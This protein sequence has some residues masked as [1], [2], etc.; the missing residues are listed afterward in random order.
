VLPRREGC[1]RRPHVRARTP[2]SE[3]SSPCGPVERR[4]DEVDRE[5]RLEK[6]SRSSFIVRVTNDGCAEWAGA[7]TWNPGSA[8][9]RINASTAST[10]PAEAARRSRRDAMASR[11]EVSARRPSPEKVQ[12]GSPSSR[13][14]LCRLAR[15]FFWVRD[16]PTVA[17]VSHLISHACVASEP[18]APLVRSFPTHCEPNWFRQTSAPSPTQSRTRAPGRR[19]RPPPSAFGRTGTDRTKES[20]DPRP[21]PRTGVHRR[22]HTGARIGQIRA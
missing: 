21:G 1:G 11:P 15:E 7:L 2:A 12:G 4:V 13:I 8:P 6:P 3:A 19:A 17:H 18:G 5:R 14:C 10:S 9:S 22:S 20:R 16:W